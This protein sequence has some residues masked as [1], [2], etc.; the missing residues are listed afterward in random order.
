MSSDS[1]R[2]LTMST[3]AQKP[4]RDIKVEL[5]L[6]DDQARHLL[7]TGRPFF[8]GDGEFAG[9][10]GVGV[11]VSQLVAA[12]SRIRYLNDHDSLTGLPN[13]VALHAMLAGLLKRP[14]EE[15]Q[16]PI[17][18]A[19]DIDR[20]RGINEAFGS[21]VGDQIIQQVAER[22]SVGL[23]PNDTL[24]RFAN[25]EFVVI[26]EKPSGLDPIP[27]LAA[28]LSETLAQPYAAGAERINVAVRIGTYETQP[29][30]R[31]AETCIKRVEIALNHSKES[32]SFVTNYSRGMDVEAETI[33]RLEEDLRQAILQDELC[34]AYQPQ[35]SLKSNRV[36][37]AE[38]LVRWNH[39]Q[40]GVN[41]RR[42]ASSRWPSEPA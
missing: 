29:E 17:L 10:R 27:A 26:R 22:I 40:H 35:L 36:A 14:R 24:T 19:F 25:D 3:A 38:A 33:R 30:D 4:F 31:N 37:V 20:F 7:L 21:S 13:R 8:D 1:Q 6:P 23:G 16:G 32:G 12:E 2:S 28:R 9:Y 41:S 34:L 11:D 18:L 39:P 5:V 15:G 42:P